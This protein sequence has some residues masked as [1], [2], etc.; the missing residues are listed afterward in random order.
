MAAFFRCQDGGPFLVSQDGGPFSSS[1]NFGLI[2]HIYHAQN[3]LFITNHGGKGWKSSN[4]TTDRQYEFSSGIKLG[5]PPSSCWSARVT[6]REVS[7]GKDQ[8]VANSTSTFQLTRVAI[9]GDVSL[10]PGSPEKSK[11]SVCSRTLAR[12]QRAVLCDCCKGLSHIK[13]CECDT[14]RVQTNSGFANLDLGLLSVHN[15]L[16]A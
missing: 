9:I 8:A 13:V 4:D 15:Y 1:D 16:H 7:R 12:N 5:Y 3:L 11:C 2:C 10:Y 14:Q 6:W